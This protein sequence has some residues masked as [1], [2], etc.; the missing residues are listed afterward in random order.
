M[1]FL[2]CPRD[3]VNRNWDLVRTCSVWACLI[4]THRHRG[5]K[6]ALR[7]GDMTIVTRS[8]RGT[9][10]PARCCTGHEADRVLIVRPLDALAAV[11]DPLGVGCPAAVHRPRSRRRGARCGRGVLPGA[12]LRQPAFLAISAARGRRRQDQ[13][14]R[15]RDRRDR[16]AL[17][18]PA[19]HGRGC[20]LSRSHLGRAPAARHK[21]WIA[22][23]GH[24]GLPLLR[25][26]AGG[27]HRSGRHGSR[28]HAGL[29]RGPQ[30]RG[31]RRTESAADV[32][33][34]TRAASGRAALRW[35]ARA[36]LVG[37][38]H[39]EDRRVDRP[40]RG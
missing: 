9:M 4:L 29:S 3:V 10:G 14:D 6:R 16:Y 40:S 33:Q 15:D 21:P 31:L 35:S 27:G 22:R 1:V 2:T 24:R 28:A 25:L 13:Q 12:P 7:R 37:R 19:L 39:P 32:P 36:D 23:A 34:P 8:W 30:G 5:C 17:R 26:R 20:R 38:R 11:A 18:E